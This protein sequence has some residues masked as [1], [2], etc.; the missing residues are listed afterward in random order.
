MKKKIERNKE[1]LAL[2]QGVQVSLLILEIKKEPGSLNQNI[3]ESTKRH[4]ESKI[5][6]LE[7]EM[8]E[9]VEVAEKA[10]LKGDLDRS[11]KYVRK[12]E[13]VN[14]QLESARNVSTHL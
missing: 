6:R 10:G 9:Y 3:D 11:Q 12:A 5:E 8:A 2:T 13:E 4:I 1:R 7:K 14:Q